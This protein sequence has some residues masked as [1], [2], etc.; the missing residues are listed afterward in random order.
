MGMHFNLPR[1]TQDTF[2]NTVGYIYLLGYVWFVDVW[3]AQTGGT[4]REGSTGKRE[5]AGWKMQL[6]LTEP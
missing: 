1:R 6:T 4:A 3:W 5:N 2:T